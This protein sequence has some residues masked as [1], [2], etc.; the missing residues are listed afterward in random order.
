[1]STVVFSNNLFPDE[2][3]ADTPVSDNEE[4]P[5]S[6]LQVF[7]DEGVSL[8]HPDIDRIVRVHNNEQMDGGSF[9]AFQGD[10]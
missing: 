3:I 10:L 4:M 8:V 7:A 6:A 2:D 9:G 5:V 1:M